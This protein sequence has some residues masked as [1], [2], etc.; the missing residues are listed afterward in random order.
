MGVSPVQWQAFARSFHAAALLAHG[1]ND[2]AH[3]LRTLQ[4][5]LRCRK[6]QGEARCACAYMAS[7]L[8]DTLLHRALVGVTRSAGA[9]AMAE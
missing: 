6:R 4:A 9:N 2:N 7:T 8:I 5:S 1:Q 3:G